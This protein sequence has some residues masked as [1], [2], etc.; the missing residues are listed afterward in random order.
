MIKYVPL[1]LFYLYISEAQVY[2][3]Y[4]R[5]VPLVDGP[6]LAPAAS[7]TYDSELRESYDIS[8][9]QATS[10]HITPDSEVPDFKSSATDLQT[11]CKPL[12]DKIHKIL[13]KGLKLEDEEYFIK[14][15]QHLYDPKISSFTTFRTIYYPP[16]PETLEIGAGTVR[17]APHSD[18]GTLTLLFQD[19]IGGLEVLQLQLILSFKSLFLR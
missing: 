15:H 16:I 3:F 11:A 4:F 6:S 17:C 5:L 7:S 9:A 2:K 10:P 8:N 14:R 1:C 19:A 12:I 18:Y 13:A